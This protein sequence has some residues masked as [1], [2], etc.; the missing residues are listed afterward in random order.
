MGVNE[1]KDDG[2]IDGSAVGVSDVGAEEG[3]AV[4]GKGEGEPEGDCEGAGTGNN[5]GNGTGT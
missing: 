3:Q 1:G 5:D 2:L 4:E